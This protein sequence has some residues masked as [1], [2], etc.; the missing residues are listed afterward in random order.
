MK[1]T[2]STGLCVYNGPN[3]FVGISTEEP[4]RGREELLSQ[5]HTLLLQLAVHNSNARE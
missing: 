4:Q 5:E 3:L 2:L 1:K